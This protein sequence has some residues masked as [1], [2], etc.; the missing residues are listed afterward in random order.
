MNKWNKVWNRVAIKNKDKSLFEISG[1]KLHKD[2]ANDISDYIDTELYPQGAEKLLEVG[3]GSGA[4]L[5]YFENKCDNIYGIDF[6]KEMIKIAREKLPYAKLNQTEANN[7]SIYQDGYFDKIFSYSV[8]QYFPSIEYGMQVVEEI[9][10]I[11]NPSWS[12]ILILDIPDVNKKEEAEKCRRSMRK[13]KNPSLLYYNKKDFL[14][15]FKCCVFDMPIFYTDNSK[16]R[17][18]LRILRDGYR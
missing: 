4:L 1:Y 18:G 17:F 3:C 8:F 9:V 11:S 12:I 2:V 5:T 16:Y 14:D 15:N 10:R 7:L 13:K 6:S